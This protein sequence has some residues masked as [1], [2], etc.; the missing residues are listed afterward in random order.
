MDGALATLHGHR[1]GARWPGAE[2]RR[3]QPAGGVRCRST[4]ARTTRSARCAPAWRC[5]PTAARTARRCSAQPRHDGFDVRVGIHTGRCCSAAGSTPKD[6]I[7]G[8]TVNI[9][10]RMEQTAP[11]GA[12]AHQ[13]RHLSPRARRVRCRVAAAASRSRAWTSRSSP[14]WCSAPSRARSVVA[15]RGIEGVETRM[16]GRDAELER[17]QQTRS[18]GCCRNAS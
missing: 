17:L 10:A 15:T 6:S 7:R 11:P 13:P 2:V 9:A 12:L 16:V 8:S 18:S 14:T 3:R 5:W 4:R 1:R